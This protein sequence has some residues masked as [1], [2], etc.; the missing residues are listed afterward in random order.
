MDL[1]EPNRHHWHMQIHSFF[2]IIRVEISWTILL[3]VFLITGP[4][5]R[6]A[7]DEPAVV[8]EIQASPSTPHV[9]KRVLQHETAVTAVDIT[10]NGNVA[11]TGSSDRFI[12]LWGSAP[13]GF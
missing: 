2:K 9:T 7:D 12:R 1:G 4:V 6:A 8:D 5:A 3:A 11:V 10:R 13:A